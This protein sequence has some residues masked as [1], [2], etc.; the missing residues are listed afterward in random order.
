LLKVPK[1]SALAWVTVS[2]TAI[3]AISIT[4]TIYY[5]SITPRPARLHILYTRS[6]QMVG[7]VVSDF[8]AWYQEK[9]GRFIEVTA[10]LTDPQTAYKK[11]MGPEADIWWGG[12]LFL[13]ERAYNRLLPYNST[14]KDEINA[15]CHSCPLMG[16]H[17]TPRWY[18]ASLYG[19]GVMYNER[20]L[21]DLAIPQTWSDLLREEYE[22]R[23]TMVD[24][25]RS[26]FTSPF[27][28]LIIQSKNWTGGWEY[29][30]RSSALIKTYDSDETDSALKVASGYIPLA[31]L[32]DFYA[33]DKMAIYPPGVGF[34][35]L[36]ATVLQP[37]P[38]AILRRG[39]YLDEAKAFIDYIL[40]RRAQSVIG[41]HR[42]PVRQDVTP[43][44]P[45][46]NPFAPNFPY[47]RDYNKTFQEIG[48]EIV[49]D[50][51]RAWIAETHEQ[52]KTAW[53]EIREANKTRHLNPNATR[54]YDLAWSNF[55]YI[56][57]YMSR[58]EV[59]I[60]YNRTNG[61]TENT[62]PYLN[63]WRDASQKAYHNAAENAEKSR[64]AA[65][66]GS[67]A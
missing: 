32:P 61:W 11:A 16:G 55:T 19:L 42:L 37:D 6:P 25:T 4:G 58:T 49:K 30:V 66:E 34:T 48:E 39:T 38:V 35:Y 9:Y 50:Y 29:L 47:V 44:P 36:D 15:T 59:D 51:Y 2:L 26:E 20:A 56:G 18:A 57:H 28:M 27:I 7:E 65:G 12:P 17:K 64:Q 67:P 43:S 8:K 33:Y 46:I 5:Y 54:Y 10:T 23:V 62:T 45:R 40:T 22:G 1:L 60:I 14:Y 24:P 63:E 53:R 3:F 13:F 41:K 52:I 31:I 21:L